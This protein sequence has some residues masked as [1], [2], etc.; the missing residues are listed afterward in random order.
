MRL[1]IHFVEQQFLYNLTLVNWF[2]FFWIF[3]LMWFKMQK[4][5]TNFIYTFAV[6]MARTLSFS[7]Q[8]IGNLHANWF[9]PQNKQKTHP[10]IYAKINSCFR[11]HRFLFFRFH[12]YK[13]NAALWVFDFRATT[14]AFFCILND[15]VDR[16]TIWPSVHCE[17][18]KHTEWI[19]LLPVIFSANV[20]S[21]NT[22]VC[23]CRARVQLWDW[24]YW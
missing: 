18:S 22:R 9:T 6:F 13:I 16:Q 4:F 14:H 21:D 15:I 10:H 11:Q 19:V 1:W 23:I 24:Q 5:R 8:I 7:L 20:I 12:I 3:L 17:V 2:Q